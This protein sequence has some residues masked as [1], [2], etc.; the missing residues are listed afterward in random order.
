[1]EEQTEW[2]SVGL[3]VTLQIMVQEVVELLAGDDIG[4]LIDH[5]A[6]AELFVERWVVSS[7]QLVHHHLP[8]GVRSRWT[9]LKF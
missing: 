4:T 1:M 9:V 5:R 7:I 3:V 2:R 6:T 8:D